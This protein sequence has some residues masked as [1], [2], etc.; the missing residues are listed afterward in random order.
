MNLRTPIA[1]QLFSCAVLHEDDTD[2]VLFGSL[3]MKTFTHKLSENI[4]DEINKFLANKPIYVVQIAQYG[5]GADQIAVRITYR[6]IT[7]LPKP[8]GGFPKTL[9]ASVLTEQQKEQWG[10]S[11]ANIR[12]S[13]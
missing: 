4:D 2:K 3:Q 9:G 10:I 7:R 12:S 8:Q 5:A 13:M 6:E 11:N 1:D